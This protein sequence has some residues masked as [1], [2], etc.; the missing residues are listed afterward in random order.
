MISKLLG[1]LVTHKRKAL[2][3]VI[4]RYG[5]Y[6]CHLATLSED[7]SLK[8]EDRAHISGYLRKWSDTKMKQIL[9]TSD[10]LKSL[11]QLDPLQW[12]TVKLV[13]CRPTEE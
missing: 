11:M 5:A 3:R 10:T 13:L 12:P 4:D 7:S 2:Q 6:M 1:G 9:K 8:S